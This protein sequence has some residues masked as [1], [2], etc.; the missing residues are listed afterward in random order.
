VTT[1]EQAALEAAF[2]MDRKLAQRGLDRSALTQ[3]D[4][5]LAEDGTSCFVYGYLDV[6]QPDD[7]V[8]TTFDVPYRYPVQS[9]LQYFLP[10]C[11]TVH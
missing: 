3:V 2:Q 4:I 11:V 10:Q 5:S 6:A 9:C 7:P 1:V 8:I